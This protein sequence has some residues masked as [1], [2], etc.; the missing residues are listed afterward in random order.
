MMIF[1]MIVVTKH[2]TFFLMM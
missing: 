1:E 2:Y